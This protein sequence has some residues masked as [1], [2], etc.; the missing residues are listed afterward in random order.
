MKWLTKFNEYMKSMFYSNKKPYPVY[1]YIFILMSLVVTMVIM[2]IF[3]KG[4]FSDTLI[5]GMCGFIATWAGIVTA[6][7]TFKN[8][9]K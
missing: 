1:A 4:A 3:Q 2:R 7:Q 9:G 8:G 6:G 5:L